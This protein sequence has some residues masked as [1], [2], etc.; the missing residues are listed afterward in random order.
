VEAFPSW[1]WV[2]WRC[3]TDESIPREGVKFQGKRLAND[4]RR[5]KRLYSQFYVHIGYITPMTKKPSNYFKTFSGDHKEILNLT[6]S[7][8][9]IDI[10]SHSLFKLW[11][12]TVNS[13]GD[14]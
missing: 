3:T 2:G 14:L 13:K 5:L 7:V 1:S 9:Q 6:S 4:I 12:N 8:A 11:L 10:F